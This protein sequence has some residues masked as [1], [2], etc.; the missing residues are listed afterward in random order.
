MMSQVR[1]APLA[2]SRCWA[3][4][5]RSLASVACSTHSSRH[6]RAI[7]RRSRCAVHL[8]PLARSRCWAAVFLVRSRASLARLTRP[9]I[10][11]R[12]T[13]AR[14]A[15]F[16]WHRSRDRAVGPLSSS[17]AR[18]RRLLDS[19]VQTSARDLPT[20]AVRIWSWRDRGGRDRRDRLAVSRAARTALG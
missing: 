7:Y 6:R 16:T 20:L 15:Q 12:S 5:F 1:L 18:E 14:G 17:F 3:A 19:L 11:A 4:V 10:G 9:D 8:A 2:R 13:D